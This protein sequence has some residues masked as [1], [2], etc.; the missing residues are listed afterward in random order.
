[1]TK[2]GTFKLFGI[3]LFFI[4][5]LGVSYVGNSA[6]EKN[7]LQ[8]PD[9]LGVLEG[10]VRGRKLT[11][12]IVNEGIE[13]EEVSDVIDVLHSAGFEIQGG[14]ATQA[15]YLRTTVVYHPVQSDIFPVVEELLGGHFKNI[16]GVKDTQISEKTMKFFFLPVDFDSIDRANISIMALNA[17]N[18]VDMESSMAA[19][20]K[21]QRF[22]KAQKLGVSGHDLSGIRILHTNQHIIDARLVDKVLRARYSGE[23]RL[24]EKEEPFGYDLMIL[25]GKE[26]KD[27]MSL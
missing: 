16:D 22:L 1:M 7:A 10:L 5:I 17:G 8:K 13:E 25:V 26:V 19:F 15:S 6:Q 2:S 12:E 11:A 14:E 3:L 9:E 20:L 27:S 4:F 21:E 24:E 23:I 18:D